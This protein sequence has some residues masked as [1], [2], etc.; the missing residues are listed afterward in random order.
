MADRIVKG[1]NAMIGLATEAHAAH[2]EHKAAKSQ[3]ASNSELK[4]AKGQE[5]SNKVQTGSPKSIPGPSMNPSGSSRAASSSSK[6]QEASKDASDFCEE[7]DPP[8]YSGLEGTAE[9]KDEADWQLDDAIA[10]HEHENEPGPPPGYEDSFDAL[11]EDE[12]GAVPSSKEGKQHYVDKIVSTFMAKHPLHSDFHPMPLP[13]AVIIPQ[14]RP[15]SKR[16][17]FVRAYAPVLENAGIDQATFLQFLKSMHQ[18]AKASPVF[19]IINV[20]AMI[21]GCVPSVACMVASTIVNIAV[22]AAMEV[23]ENQRNNDFLT[24]MNEKFFRPRGLYCLIFAYEPEENANHAQVD[25]SQTIFNKIN[26]TSDKVSQAF[27]KVGR[28]SGKTYGKIEM[29]KAAPLIF[30]S[31]DEIEDTTHQSSMK[32]KGKFVANYFD[33]RAQAAYTTE[34]PDSTLVRANPAQH[35]FASRYADPN[36]P[37]NSGH[38]I[39]L[40]TGGYINPSMNKGRGRDFGGGFG[41]RGY[42]GGFGG[43]GGGSLG[44]V[45]G[46]V[47]ALM[48]KGK[49]ENQQDEYQNQQMQY[50][51]AQQYGSHGG[52]M[53]GREQLAYEREQMLYDRPQYGG[54]AGMKG[55]RGQMMGGPGYGRGGSGGANQGPTGMEQQH[56]APSLVKRML[57]PVSVRLGDIL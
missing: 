39:S 18:S 33:K 45:V 55:G 25:I 43:G 56:N 17:G 10:E 3:G 51:Q 7:A 49:G 8:P 15:H 47:A 11:P 38:P 48:N 50:D 12:L 24:Q 52:K 41:G 22:M 32:R 20:A 21:V 57:T 19:G 16:R 29:P 36:H 44:L 4:I 6:A 13:S 26:P 54:R 53:G 28:S 35:K 40:L 27:H 37:V 5:V 31:L 30:P 14:R 42:G 23:Q 1:V 46:G 9:E 34:N 2:K